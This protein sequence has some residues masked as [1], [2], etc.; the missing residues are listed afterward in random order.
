MCQGRLELASVIRWLES[1]VVADFTR[2]ICKRRGGSVLFAFC[3][4]KGKP[5]IELVEVRLEALFGFFG[6]ASELDSHDDAGI[7]R[8][9]HGGGRQ[10]IFSDPQ[11]HPKRSADV[12]RH[13]S[14]NITTIP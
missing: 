1:A 11:V 9:N 4:R 13:H 7:A 3:L 8:A 14:L 2:M 10:V 5:G 6:Q 12:E